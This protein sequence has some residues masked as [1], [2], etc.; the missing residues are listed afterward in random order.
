MSHIEAAKFWLEAWPLII[1][2][3]FFIGWYS[4]RKMDID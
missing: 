3:S 4:M 1:V 2:F